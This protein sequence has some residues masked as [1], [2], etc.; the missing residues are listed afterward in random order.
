MTRPP[1]SFRE[2]Q[3]ELPD[4]PSPVRPSS[5]TIERVAPRLESHGRIARGY[6]G[7]GLQ[8]IKLDDG[9][10]AMVMS[11]NRAGPSA[12]AGIRQGDVIV[13]WNEQSLSSVRALLRA[14]GPESVG[15]VVDVAVRR[16]GEPARFKVTIGVRPET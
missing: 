8:P 3:A 16:G 4:A 2:N 15:S 7:L 12:S 6:L 13:G 14:L 11:I 1:H 5:A 10:G 9:V